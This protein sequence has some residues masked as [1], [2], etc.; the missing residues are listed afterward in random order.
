MNTKDRLILQ[1]SMNQQ[2][3]IFSNIAQTAIQ[4]RTGDISIELDDYNSAIH[5]N[6]DRDQ[7]VTLSSDSD[8]QITIEGINYISSVRVPTMEQFFN[9]MLKLYH[10]GFG[11]AKHLYV[12]LSE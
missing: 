10:D 8:G 5:F 4:L 9:T 11:A 12:K 7:N 1:Q 6:Y 2:N 3:S